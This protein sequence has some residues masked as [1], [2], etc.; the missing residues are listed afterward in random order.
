M[1]GGRGRDQKASGHEQDHLQ[2]RESFGWMRV[3]HCHPVPSPTA[4]PGAPAAAL[5]RTERGADSLRPLS[6]PTPAKRFKHLNIAKRM[7]PPPHPPARGRG[8]QGGQLGGAERPPAV[9]TPLL[10]AAELGR[11]HQRCAPLSTAPLSFSI[12]LPCPN[13]PTR[14]QGG[15]WAPNIWERP[16]HAAPAPTAAQPPRE[17]GNPFPLLIPAK[18]YPKSPPQVPPRGSSLVTYRKAG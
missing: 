17:Q 6:C 11:W 16:W 9:G 5:P 1:G 13:P 7:E 12:P 2:G 14:S 15:T 10:A 8:E 18:N 4:V 3:N